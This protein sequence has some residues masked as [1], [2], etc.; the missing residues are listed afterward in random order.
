MNLRT[1]VEARA[2]I[3]T[4]GALI[5]RLRRDATVALD[6]HVLHAGFIYDERGRDRLRQLYRQYLDIGAAADLPMIVCTPTWRASLGRLQRAGLA[7]QDVNGDGARFLSSIRGEYGPYAARVWIGG[8]VGCMG[9][10]TSPR[11][12]CPNATPR[13]PTPGR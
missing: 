12:G 2:V 4:E 5:E 13:T 3:L 10:P 6:P 1:A 11:R 7:G 8:L 9:T